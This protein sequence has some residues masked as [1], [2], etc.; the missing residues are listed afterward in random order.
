MESRARR[1]TAQQQPMFDLYE[2]PFDVESKD[3]EL[4]EQRIKELELYLGIEGMD[5]AF[6]NEQQGED[7]N[8]K[9]MM[10]EDFMQAAQESYSSINDI[11]AKFEKLDHFL[12]HDKPFLNQCLDLKQ[13]TNFIID[14][15]DDLKKFITDLEQIKQKEN[16]LAFDP[17]TGKFI[18]YE[19]F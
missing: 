11:F 17:I 13:K 8:T 16:H 6:F 2:G 9:S 7:L 14:W 1:R 3:L 18:Y 15:L 19:Q 5:Q 4:L 10:L 12:K